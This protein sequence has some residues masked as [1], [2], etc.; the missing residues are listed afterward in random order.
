MHNVDNKCE[1]PLHAW[2]KPFLSPCTS[3]LEFCITEK[4][5][6]WLFP[7][8][9]L[10]KKWDTANKR[11]LCDPCR[12]EGIVVLWPNS[13]HSSRDSDTQHQVPKAAMCP[14]HV[15]NLPPSGAESVTIQK[16]LFDGGDL[17]FLYFRICWFLRVGTSHLQEN[18]KNWN[19]TCMLIWVQIQFCNKITVVFNI[20]FLVWNTDNAV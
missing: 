11:M 19:Q 17:Y 12:I 10:L 9:T 13:C 6:P 3:F 5:L 18:G 20:E 4:H 15:A 16:D 8:L 7:A 2:P 14:P 1:T